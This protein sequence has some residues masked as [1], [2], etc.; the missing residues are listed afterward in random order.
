MKPSNV[1]INKDRVNQATPMRCPMCDRSLEQVMIRD[2]GG[3]TADL[4]WQLHAG[5]CP[6][7][8]W[9]QCEVISKP[10]R[11]IFPVTRPFGVARPVDVNGTEVYAFSTAWNA[12]SAEERR[13]KVD[14]FDRKYWAVRHSAQR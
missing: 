7:H 5:H 11:E 4:I 12:L 6:D 8:G 10:P 1:L 2:L 9:F 13:G 14:P 3:V